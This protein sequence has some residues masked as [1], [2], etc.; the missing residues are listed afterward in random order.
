MDDRPRQNPAY[1]PTHP[2]STAGRPQPPDLG[3][4]VDSTS[5]RLHEKTCHQDWHRRVHREVCCVTDPEVYVRRWT[6]SMAGPMECSLCRSVNPP[7][8]K[9]CDGCGEPLQPTCPV[10]GHNVP[11][12]ARFCPNCGHRLLAAPEVDET[13]SDLTRYLPA[14]L[15]AKIEAARSGRAMAGERRLV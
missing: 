12:D 7:D 3:F 2:P 15:L 5:G 8:A 9:F 6:L 4:W 10:C 14:T 11:P 13:T 1:R